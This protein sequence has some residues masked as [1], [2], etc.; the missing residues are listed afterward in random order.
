MKILSKI[1]VSNW[2]YN[3][4][5]EYCDTE[6]E[7]DKSDLYCHRGGQRDGDSYYAD[8]P[9]CHH[10]FYIAE[11]LLPKLLR[12]EIKKKPTTEEYYGR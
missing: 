7:V 6:L 10:R 4:K 9:V 8:C 5:C 12:L 1:D 11:R 3:H 2:S